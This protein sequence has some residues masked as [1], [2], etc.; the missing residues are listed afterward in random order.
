MDQA[1]ILARACF[2]IVCDL[3]THL[4]FLNEGH[5]TCPLLKNL[6]NGITHG[7]QYSEGEHVSF[8]C[9]PGYWLHGLSERKCLTNGTWTGKQPSCILGI[10]DE[11]CNNNYGIKLR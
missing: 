9:N 7:Q 1:L 6:E 8:T 5:R 11:F 2:V 4:F 10:K 3:N